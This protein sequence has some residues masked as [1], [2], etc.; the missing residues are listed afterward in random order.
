[1]KLLI[2]GY[3]ANGKDT[4]AEYWQK[5]FGLTFSSSSLT[6]CKIFL[7]DYL[8]DKYNYKTYEECFNDRHNHRQEWF[9]L[10]K[11]YNKDDGANCFNLFVI[12]INTCT[13][14]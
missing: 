6:A 4:V 13:P 8:K 12:L 10:I 5:E 3:G 14:R 7:F 9:D 2:I 1:M 11:D